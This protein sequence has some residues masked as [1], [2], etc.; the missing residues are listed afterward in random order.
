MSLNPRPKQPLEE[1]K[2][3]KI[4][5]AFFILGILFIAACTQSKT[6]QTDNQQTNNQ[7][8]PPPKPPTGEVKNFEITAKQWE[9]NPN[10]ITV[11]E[12]DTV[13]IRVK[14]LDVT[15]GFGISGYNINKVVNPGDTVD[16]ELIA[17]QKGTFNFIC[18]V[19]CGPGHSSMKG[20]LIVN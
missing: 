9:F 8:T 17:D 6:D 11:N 3:K 16:V 15:H 4:F 5:I 13:K 2:I 20:K 14:S 12:G 10:T 19:P 18:T 7:Q 1:T